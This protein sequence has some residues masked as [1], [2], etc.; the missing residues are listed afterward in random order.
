MSDWLV[1]GLEGRLFWTTKETKIQFRGRELL[2]RPPTDSF[3]ADI[4]T[5]YSPP[6]THDE[7]LVIVRQFLSSLAW[8]RGGTVREIGTTGG[9]H[10]IH[11]GKASAHTGQGLQSALVD[12]EVRLDYLPDP[13]DPRTRLALAFYREALG[14]NNLSYKFLGFFKI[15]NVLH[16]NGSSQVSWINQVIDSLYDHTAKERIEQ[17]KTTEI[18]VG[19]Y[20]YQSGRCAVAHAFAEPLVDPENPEDSKRLQ[21][22]LPVVKALAQYVIE[23]EFG[24]KSEQT[25]WREHLYQLEGFRG[26]LGQEILGR[27]KK[28]ENVEV[29][30]IPALP[31]LSLMVRGLEHLNIFKG[32]DAE[33]IGISEGCLFV[34]CHSTDKLAHCRLCLN[35]KEELLEFDPIEG[36]GILDDGTSRSAKYGADR[37]RIKK[38]LCLN[39]VLEVWNAE[40]D[41]LFGRTDPFMFTNI[42]ISASVQNLDREIG[43][44]EQMAKDREGQTSQ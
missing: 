15:I 33:I 8:V 35:L 41:M 2:L 36:M 29:Q 17:L 25:I 28:E 1:V 23:K 31:R 34:D 14:L 11:I 40:T 5:T 38:Q 9:S 43:L 24:V 13:T 20:L 39:G 7:A 19:Q 30:E 4:V 22:D 6:G 10:P 3:E 21:R 44:Y 26:A 18:N 37:A 42:D 32:V 16:K 27:I 12:F